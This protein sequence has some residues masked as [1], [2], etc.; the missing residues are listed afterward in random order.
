MNVAIV[1]DTPYQVMNAISLKTCNSLFCDECVDLYIGHQ[2]KNSS[3]ISN[4]IKEKKI[5]ANVYD[6]YPHVSSEKENFFFT[7]LLTSLPYQPLR[8][9]CSPF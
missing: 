4:L 7:L 3:M 9:H 1:A 8:I 2:F 5:F 6:F